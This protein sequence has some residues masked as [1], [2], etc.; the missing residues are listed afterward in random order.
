MDHFGSKVNDIRIRKST[1]NKKLLLIN[2][3]F[4]IKK[5]IK[6]F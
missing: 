4:F 3:L 2:K 1:N 5:I 6:Y